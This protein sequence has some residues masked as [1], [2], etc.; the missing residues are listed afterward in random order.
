VADAPAFVVNRLLTR[1][2]GAVFG[3]I[4]A[5]TPVAVAD[6][7]LDPMGLPIR[8]LALLQLVGPAVA[9]HVGQVLHGAFPDRFPV[10]ENMRRIAE[11]GLP[12]LVDDKPNPELEALLEVG[13]NPLSAEQV[14]DK[15][16]T[17]LAEEESQRRKLS[18]E[19]ALAGDLRVMTKQLS[20]AR[21]EALA[22]LVV[23]SALTPRGSILVD[24]RTN[25]LILTELLRLLAEL[26]DGR[27]RCRGVEID[28][29][30]SCV[31]DREV[32][33]QASALEQQV[34]RDIETLFRPARL[35]IGVQVK[36]QGGRR[37]TAAQ[38]EL[39]RGVATH[40]QGR[41]FW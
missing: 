29:D 16:L 4:E 38:L 22:L 19:Q 33:S 32:G 18:Q 41:L 7:A 20:Q 37:R 31:A 10:S 36:R 17:V 14:L 15:A 6:S 1:F 34:V 27:K 30:A 25:T 39:C 12:L 2:Q 24:L 8:P 26:G 21:A 35:E 28:P 13:A 9:H 40:G 23:K 3:A 11:A 5:G